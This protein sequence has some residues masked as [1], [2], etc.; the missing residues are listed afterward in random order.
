MKHPPKPADPLDPAAIGPCFYFKIKRLSR[1]IGRCYDPFLNE[2]GLKGTQ[3][4]LLSAIYQLGAP[5]TGELSHVLGL[6][7][8]TLTRN[9]TVLIEKNWIT[10]EKK[11]RHNHYRLTN[12]GKAIFTKALP[13]WRHAQQ[14][15]RHQVGAQQWDS[16][17]HEVDVVASSLQTPF[18]QKNASQ[19]VALIDAVHRKQ[20]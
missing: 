4:S 12:E 2:I 19:P 13:L 1:L 5:S 11:S 16:F 7:R 17:L 14:A 20:G 18:A 6:D 10:T 3:F 8:T 9:T 15:L